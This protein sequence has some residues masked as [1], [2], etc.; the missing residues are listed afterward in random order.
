MVE[1]RRRKSGETEFHNILFLLLLLRYHW[2]LVLHKHMTA[3]FCLLL[4][5]ILNNFLCTL[6][7]I[8]GARGPG[9]V[10]KSLR[11]E[12]CLGRHYSCTTFFS[13]VFNLPSVVVHCEFNS[14]RFCFEKNYFTKKNINFEKTEAKQY[15]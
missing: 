4:N 14:G 13:S 7:C 10:D 6:K 1:G 15:K 3:V 11:H 2:P 8:A 9:F 5:G 12:K